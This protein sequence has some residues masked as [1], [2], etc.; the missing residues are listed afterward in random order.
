MTVTHTLRKFVK[1]RTPNLVKYLNN[2]EYYLL[3]K[4]NGKQ[5][6]T[7]LKTL[8]YKVAVRRR[9]AKMLEV[10]KLRSVALVTFRVE[11]SRFC[12]LFAIPKKI[13]NRLAR[14]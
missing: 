13:S 12:L 7:S 6:R 5:I 1:T 14:F 11:P 2:G 10:D 8:D 9:N 3:Y 4:L